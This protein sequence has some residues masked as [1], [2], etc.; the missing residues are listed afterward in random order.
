[1]PPGT[2]IRTPEMRARTALARTGTT[3]SDATKAKLSAALMGHPVSDE[4]RRK[5]S[6]TNMGNTSALGNTSGLHHGHCRERISRTYRSWSGMRQRCMNPSATSFERYGGRGITV[7]DRW[8]SFELFYAD[9]GDRPDG[10]TLD[11]IDND[12][13]YSPDNCRWATLSQQQ[14]N[15]RRYQPNSLR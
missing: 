14:R 12:G 15:S 3:L 6:E 5:L 11:R 7:C 13:P 9:M 2:Y 8:Q 10:M 4:T 1:M